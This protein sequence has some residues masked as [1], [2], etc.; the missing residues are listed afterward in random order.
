MKKVLTLTLI[1]VSNSLVHSQVIS[2]DY[3][4]TT[5]TRD[6]VYIIN[7]GVG[8]L[9]Y[10]SWKVDPVWNGV[11]PKI[12]LVEDLSEYRKKYTKNKKSK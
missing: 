7:N 4:V 3:V 1:I 6:K 9:I 10:D 2:N 12:Y 8:K 11:E 5:P